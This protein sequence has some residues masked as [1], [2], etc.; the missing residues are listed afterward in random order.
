MF[1]DLEKYQQ[2]ETIEHAVC[3]PSGE[4]VLFPVGGKEVQLT[5][6]LASQDCEEARKLS[7]VFQNQSFRLMAKEAQKAAEG[8]KKKKAKAQKDADSAQ[9][10][11]LHD[12]KLVLA[13][14]KGWNL[15]Q[16]GKPV[17]FS[18]E[19]AKELYTH[20]RFP[21][22]K[23]EVLRVTRDR[24]RFDP[25]AEEDSDDELE[26]DEDFPGNS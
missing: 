20:P 22:I 6:T 9:A 11:E 2:E 5:L 26:E 17:P 13:C 8:K 10:A 3:T 15:H 25:T 12:L 14:T 18:R 4:P 16:Q 19:A 1:S 21:F 7:R 24:K 23:D